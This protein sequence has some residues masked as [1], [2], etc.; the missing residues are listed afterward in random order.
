MTDITPTQWGVYTL[1]I[2]QLLKRQRDI[3]R[4]FIRFQREKKS[5]LENLKIT[6]DV[7]LHFLRYISEL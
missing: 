5:L 4:N 1:C 6:K 2:L 7:R 3:K